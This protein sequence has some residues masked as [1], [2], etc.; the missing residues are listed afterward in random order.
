MTNNEKILNRIKK[1]LAMG[2]S[3]N[4]HESAIAL[5]QAMLL[6]QKHGISNKDIDLSQVKESST[7]TRS[8]A[9]CPPIWLT[10]LATIVSK[11][12]ACEDI[13]EIRNGSNFYLF[14]GVG[15]APEVAAYT[16]T[17]LR[18]Q[19]VKSRSAYFKKLRG[20]RVN[21]IRRADVYALAW[22]HSVRAKVEELAGEV[23][24]IVRTYITERVS[25]IVQ[26]QPKYSGKKSDAMDAVNGLIDGNSVNL[27]HGVNGSA[28]PLLSAK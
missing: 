20:K 16:F 24:K 27:Y 7:T 3:C 17:I 10:Q 28:Q 21:R 19:L 23:P 22:T 6:M 11:A 2:S 8:T 13:Y 1:L 9:S 5:R 15:P 14:I 26:F 4:P 25:G 18:R 12:F